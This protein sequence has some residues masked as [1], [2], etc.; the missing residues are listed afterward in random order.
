MI[1]QHSTHSWLGSFAGRLIQLRPHI[2]VGGAVTCAVSS[3]HY[4]A[5]IDPRRA[6]ELFVIANPVT[7]TIRRARAA[8]KDRSAAAYRVL[9]TLGLLAPAKGDSR[10]VA[11]A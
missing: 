11:T 1:D 8:P 3:I 2:S 7:K 10:R 5:D 9:S 6:A 4:A